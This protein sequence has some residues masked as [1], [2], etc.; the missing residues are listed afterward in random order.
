MLRASEIP[1]LALTLDSNDAF[2]TED[3][4]VDA[5]NRCMQ[6]LSRRNLKDVLKFSSLHGM[7]SFSLASLKRANF[8]TIKAK[9]CQTRR[10]AYLS[11]R[12]I[13]TITFSLCTVYHH[14][15]LRSI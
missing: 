2:D 3:L 6:S 15:V 11:P 7:A 12:S 1:T 10:T 4:K 14:A 9:C 8:V 13:K 5:F